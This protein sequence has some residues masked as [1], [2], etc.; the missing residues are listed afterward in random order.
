[1]Q[2]TF[3]QISGTRVSDLT[4]LRHLPLR[5]L[6]MTDCA[7]ITNIQPLAGIS[8]LTSVI[9]PPNATGLDALRA[10]TNLTHL[11]F[12]YDPTTKGPTQTAAEFWAEF[13]R[14]KAARE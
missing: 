1:M 5:E 12:K 3:L 2:L 6:K 13:D 9:L 10:L 7:A 14:N 11:G 8:T 4:P